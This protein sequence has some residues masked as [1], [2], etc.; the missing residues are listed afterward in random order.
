MFMKKNPPPQLKVLPREPSRILYLRGGG[1]Y[2]IART[3]V[4]LE[5]RLLRR[6]GAR[7]AKLYQSAWWSWRRFAKGVP[8]KPATGTCKEGDDTNELLRLNAQVFRQGKIPK[9]VSPPV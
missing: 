3:T 5:T 4:N 1:R 9:P 7:P 8:V 6:S 2:A